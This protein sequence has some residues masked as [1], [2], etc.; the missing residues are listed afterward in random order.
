MQPNS[1]SYVGIWSWFNLI[2]FVVWYFFVCLM[3]LTLVSLEVVKLSC[4]LR[5]NELTVVFLILFRYDDCSSYELN[6]VSIPLPV[7][8]NLGTG[9]GCSLWLF[10]VGLNLIRVGRLSLPQTRQGVKSSSSS[11]V[12]LGFYWHFLLFFTAIAFPSNQY[13]GVPELVSGPNFFI[14][15]S[16]Q[17]CFIFKHPPKSLQLPST[18]H[19]SMRDWTQ[20]FSQELLREVIEHT[21]RKVPCSSFEWVVGKAKYPSL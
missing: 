21:E 18:M 3:L 13:S 12:C 14:P 11:S 15:I 6:R 2:S 5:S 16:I 1:S 9:A 17:Y 7:P 20:E 19:E 4:L 8:I 10:E